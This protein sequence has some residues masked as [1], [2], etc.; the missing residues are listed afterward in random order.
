MSCV[1]STYY[2][3]HYLKSQPWISR[4]QDIVYIEQFWH[5][6][7]CSANSAKKYLLY[8][9]QLL[10]MSN[11]KAFTCNKILVKINFITLPNPLTATNSKYYNSILST[12]VQPPEQFLY[13]TMW[14]KFFYYPLLDIIVN[15]CG[16]T[17]FWMLET[18]SGV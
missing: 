8:H 14:I 12:N 2:N 13:M 16:N 3:F 4:S 11:T 1:S 7:N 5:F 9:S 10:K 15:N 6:Q 17:V 18:D